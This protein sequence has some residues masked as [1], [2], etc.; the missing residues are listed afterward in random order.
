MV[1]VL[2]GRDIEIW[3]TPGLHKEFAPFV[4]YKTLPRH[5]DDVTSLDWLVQFAIVVF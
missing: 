1:S 2:L 3:R 4:L 5:H